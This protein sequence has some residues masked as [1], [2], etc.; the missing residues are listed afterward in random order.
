MAGKTKL[1][2]DLLI[3]KRKGL[4]EALRFLFA[5][6][7][8]DIWRKHK[9]MGELTTFWLSRHDQFRRAATALNANNHAFLE[10]KIDP[11]TFSHSMVPGFN[12]LLGGLTEHHTMEDHHYFPKFRV[13]EPK[14][15]RGFEILDEDH[16][17]LHAAIENVAQTANNFMQSE[18]RDNLL[19][20]G[21]KFV[22]ANSKLLAFLM[23]HLEDEE[24]LIV[25]LLLDRSEAVVMGQ[26]H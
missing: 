13:V 11:Q 16:H 8:R 20:T 14:L 9:N 4:P 12:A 5:D 1:P 3:D 25:P 2:D 22:D 17:A 19:R 18:G 15:S 21:D 10:G 7:P 26:G 23:R 6:Y 24:D